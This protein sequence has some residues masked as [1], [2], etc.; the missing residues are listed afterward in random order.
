MGL[1]ALNRAGFNSPAVQPTDRLLAI[2]LVLAILSIGPFQGCALD[3]SLAIAASEVAGSAVTESIVADLT[4]A[5]EIRTVDLGK[6]SEGEEL[7][8]TFAI[9]N[10]SGQSFKVVAIKKSCGCETANVTEGTT[11]PPG[12][13]LEVG[14]ALSKYGVGK[15]NGQLVITTDAED[16]S[17]RVIE[18]SLRGEIQAK[19]WATP[20]EV[21]LTADDESTAE[22]LLRVESIVPGL[23]DTFQDV[24][25]NR[26]NVVVQLAEK[27][28]DAL[29]FRVSVAPA[30]PLGTSY[31]LIYVSFNSREHP[32]LNV[33]TRV[34]KGQPLVLLPTTLI[35][36]PF[37][38]TES[39]T[40]RVRIMSPSAR[41]GTF[42]I[43]RVE[44][45]PGIFVDEIPAEARQ[46]F[47]LNL[48]LTQ[49][50]S[51]EVEQKVTIHTEPPGCVTLAV[52][53]RRQPAP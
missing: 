34:R 23:L 42:Q 9:R 32:S 25:T 11:V 10:T 45:P 13:Q 46:A 2:T 47:D 5:E 22:Q 38:S 29:V 31:D 1:P 20:T 12:R 49:P 16:E 37:N 24:S 44:S 28:A 8:H 4:V 41:T 53:Y 6:V 15:R 3:G 40:R 17:L 33:R 52:R 19:I 50:D 51:A 35:L 39:Q 30:A 27:A 14:Y 43:T 21:Q 26:G 48:T 36:P 18:L 7:R